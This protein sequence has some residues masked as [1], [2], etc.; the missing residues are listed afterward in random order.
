MMRHIAL[1][2][3]LFVSGPLFLIH[4]SMSLFHRGVVRVGTSKTTR[5]PG[6]LWMGT[7]WAPD[8]R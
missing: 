4:P 2:K 3:L 1:G 5:C 8:M 7:T 6:S